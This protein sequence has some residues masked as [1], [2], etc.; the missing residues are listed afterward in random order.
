MIMPVVLCDADNTLWDT[1][2]VFADAQRALL[3]NIESMIGAQ[4]DRP[5]RL[6]F[7]RQYDQ[8]LALIHHLHLRYPPHLL[9]LALTEGLNGKSPETAAIQIVSGISQ[10]GPISLEAAEE[11][12]S[13]FQERLKV[14]PRLLPGVRDGL[15]LA[16]Q[17]DV[18]IYMLT[19]GRI[20][21][22]KRIIE[23]H[24]LSEN[25]RAVL[26]MTKS[27]QQ[28]ERLRSRFLPAEVVVLGDQLDRDIDPARAAGCT[29]VYV[30]GRFTPSW[31][32]SKGS[33]H[34]SYQAENFEDAM[35][36][37]INRVVPYFKSSRVAD[38]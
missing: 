36:W 23:S 25:F 14:I 20:D 32:L 28:Y 15:R 30:P 2:A 1:D 21:K 8:A 10:A 37:I 18:P 13:L 33:Q 7:V 9:V 5:D 6:D 38:T 31:N 4:C 27:L 11:L 17:K 16:L 35:I 26:E 29:T 3:E 22:Q 24:K 19:E 34:A 12:G